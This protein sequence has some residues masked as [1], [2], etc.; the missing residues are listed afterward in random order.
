MSFEFISKDERKISVFEKY[1]SEIVR[2]AFT[3]GKKKEIGMK[4]D[5][6]AIYPCLR[7]IEKEGGRKPG[8]FPIASY[9]LGRKRRGILIPKREIEGELMRILF[10]CNMSRLC[11]KTPPDGQ[12]SPHKDIHMERA[13]PPPSI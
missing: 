7:E 3:L 11:R 9:D 2:S 8:D 4:K 5:R 10:L 13:N 1:F 12:R 6:P